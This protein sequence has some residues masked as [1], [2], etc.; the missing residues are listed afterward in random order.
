[1]KIVYIHQHFGTRKDSSGT[2]SYEFA[3]RLIDRGHEVVMICATRDSS[4][5]AS[6]NESGFSEEVIDGIRVIRSSIRYSTKL[7]IGQRVSSFT[8]FA[9]STIKKVKAEKNVD[10]VFATST[11]LTVAIPGVLGAKYHKVPFMLEI[12]DLWP[13]LPK[14]LG[15]RN[16]F[17]LFPMKQLELW[18]YRNAQRIIALAPGI[19]AGIAQTGY[20]EDKIALIPNSADIDVF[21]PAVTSNTSKSI[22]LMF[23]G[24]HGIANGLDAVIN[25]AKVLQD[26]GESGIQFLFI[27]SGATKAKLIERT[28]ELSLLNVMFYNPVPKI[29]LAR[30]LSDADVGM[31]ILKNVPAFYD[32]TSP[33]KYFDY[34]AS[35][36]PVLVNYPGWLKE[37]IER[38]GCGIYVPPD[39]P[40]A[41]ADAVVR[42]RDN[43][44]ERIAMGLRSRA[45]AVRDYAR[46]DL[47]ERFIEV[48][49]SARQEWRGT[50]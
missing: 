30:V 14:A 12:R 39:D 5:A 38:E 50:C 26:R 15:V 21:K 18:A 32:G 27:G 19:K 10:L 41:F 40:T 3:R 37:M 49:E 6:S 47:A 34:I 1:M 28:K 22:K 36:L 9:L 8:K 17:L 42:L 23:T 2:R 43:P 4:P 11:P 48:L 44:E 31:M 35:G 13:E 20:P 45:L 16:P 25:A 7:S 24:A 33:N 46:D 29:E